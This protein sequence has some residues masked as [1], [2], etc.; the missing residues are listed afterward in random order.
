M[1]IYPLPLLSS[2]ETTNTVA[3]WKYN[4]KRSADGYIAINYWTDDLQ[5]DFELSDKDVF[6]T[7]KYSFTNV[8][9]LVASPR[10]QELGVELNGVLGQYYGGSILSLGTGI[11]WKPSAIFNSTINYSFNEIKSEDYSVDFRANIGWVK[12]E[13]TFNTQWSCAAFYPFS[14]AAHFTLMNF[15]LR[16]NPRE[17]NDLYLVYNEGM[18]L[19]RDREM[20]VLPVTDTRTLLLKYT[21]TFVW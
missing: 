7:D 1:T 11:I 13:L 8:E 14:A 12:C 6:T 10:G 16:Y 9:F 19:H 21:H 17:G 18:N 2:L 20:P 4:T 5:E 3:S 15:R